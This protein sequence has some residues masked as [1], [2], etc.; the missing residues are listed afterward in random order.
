MK[1]LKIIG[2]ISLT[3]TLISLL[4]TS[5]GEDEMIA[6]DPDTAE[7]V[8]VDRFSDAAGTLM[9]RSENPTLPAANA[10]I[11]F[12]VDPF[13][14]QS[15]GP[16]GEVVKYYN[17]DVM[18]IASAPIYV[19]FREG[20]DTPLE[21][22]LNIINV[23]PGDA[24]YNDF[25]RMYKVFVPDEYVANAYTS[26]QEIIDAGYD[27]E[28]TNTIVNCPVVPAGSTANLRYTDESINYDRGWYKGKVV[29]YF[30]FMEDEILSNSSGLV[31]L[32]PIYVTFNVNPDE[33]NPD[34]GPPSGFV[35]ETGSVQTH[36]VIATI[37][38]D[39]DYS[40]F[41]SVYI[42]DNADFDNVSDL[43]SAL[44]A[45]ILMQGAAYVNCPVVYVESK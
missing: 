14:T 39:A 41:W 13:I 35:M 1:Q 2:L 4:F 18:P 28:F 12:D 25:W 6:M 15:F 16:N 37:P 36:N 5:C 38:G 21:D 9:K 22:Q 44:N 40:P 30:T 26:F 31:L 33:N 20:S 8:S 42:Y 45:N 27:I 3:I 34:S 29:Y 17:F 10:A 19:L 7:I 23:I 32:S 43:P 24:A 11:N